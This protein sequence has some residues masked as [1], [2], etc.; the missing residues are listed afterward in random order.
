[1]AGD[2]SSA[3]FFLIPAALIPGS[4]ILLRAVGLNPTRTGILDIVDR[5]GAVVEPI[6]V[7]ESGGEPLADLRVRASELP[8]RG[9]EVG[10]SEIPRAIDELPLIAL[11]ACFAD[12]PTV[13]RDAAELRRKESDRI[14]T[15][16]ASLRAI[17][18]EIEATEDGMVVAGPSAGSDGPASAPLRG[19]EIDSH[20]D[21]RIAMLGAVAGLISGEGV[22]VRNM[23]AA[24]VSYPNFSADLASLS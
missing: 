24:A 7:R 12:G 4:D 23:E 22:R 17:G 1:M 11:A 18:A 19:G 2:I 16:V 8:L 5:M 3:A 10:G 14:E 13:I 6:N 20:G 9:T 21:H 15:T